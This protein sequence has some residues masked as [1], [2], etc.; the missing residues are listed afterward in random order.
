MI[1]EHYGKILFSWNELSSEIMTIF[2]PMFSFGEHGIN[3]KLILSK[4]EENFLDMNA[5]GQRIL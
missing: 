4:K 3:K 1:S 5:S 2:Q